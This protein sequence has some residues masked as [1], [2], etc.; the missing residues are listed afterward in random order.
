MSHHEEAK[1]KV[2]AKPAP[3]AGKAA[4]AA[5]SAASRS[6]NTGKVSK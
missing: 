6:P 2:P 5:K 1:K 3:A 4:G